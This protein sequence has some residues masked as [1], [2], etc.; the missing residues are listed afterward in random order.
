MH[1]LEIHYQV[2]KNFTAAQILSPE[3]QEQ[4]AVAELKAKERDLEN[5]KKFIRSLR[6]GKFGT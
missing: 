3:M 6:H 2:F 4:Q 1:F 5:R